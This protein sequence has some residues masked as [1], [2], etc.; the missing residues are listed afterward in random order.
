M[1]IAR[2]L[3]HRWHRTVRFRLRHERTNEIDGDIM[4]GVD[5]ESCYEL[6]S[7]STKNVIGVDGVR[8]GMNVPV[9]MQAVWTYSTFF[10]VKG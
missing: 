2:L 3:P 4:V 10:Y 1:D 6:K 5:Q 9:I 8:D 7:S